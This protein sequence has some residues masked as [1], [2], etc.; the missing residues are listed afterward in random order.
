[1]GKNSVNYVYYLCLIDWHKILTNEEMHN[2]KKVIKNLDKSPENNESSDEDWIKI[3]LEWE[4]DDDLKKII[5]ESDLGFYHSRLIFSLKLTKAPKTVTETRKIRI[6]LEKKIRAF[7]QNELIKEIKK[8]T[9]DVNGMLIFIYP[10]FELYRK[11]KFWD[12]ERKRPYSLPTTCFFTKLNDRKKKYVKMR[13]SGAKIITMDMSIWLFEILVNI[14]FH[15]GLYRQTREKNLKLQQSE[16]KI[17]G[18]LENRL[19]DF[20]SKLMTIFH[21]YSSAYSVG[22]IQR[23]AV[24]VSIISLILGGIGVGLGIIGFILGIKQI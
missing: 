6:K 22:R 17:Y 14:V 10:I 13:I 3:K 20:A 5:S 19:E 4:N 16:E 12:F 7:F 21:Q 23:I 9:K 11:E 15:E 1:M 2:F 24:G 8:I 18:G